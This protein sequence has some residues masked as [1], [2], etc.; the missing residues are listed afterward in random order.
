MAL[1]LFTIKRVFLIWVY[2]VSEVYEVQRELGIK[3]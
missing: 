3:C 1:K 2:E